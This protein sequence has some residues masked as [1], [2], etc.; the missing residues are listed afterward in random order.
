MAAPWLSTGAKLPEC[1]SPEPLEAR[2][3]RTQCVPRASKITGQLFRAVIT[4]GRWRVPKTAVAPLAAHAA[5]REP[6]GAGTP[7][8]LPPRRNER[9]VAGLQARRPPAFPK[10]PT[11]DPVWEEARL[12]PWARGPMADRTGCGLP[13]SR[14]A[15]GPG[16]GGS[17]SQ[18]GAKRPL[19]GESKRPTFAHLALMP[20][21][22]PDNKSVAP[23][24]A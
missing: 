11:G 3:R 4:F 20:W 14:H 9:A 24:V 15:Q 2:A 13:A 22:V 23:G 18:A 5:P 7:A 12:A 21:T 1:F 8:A 16:A 19:V 17:G 6:P 10:R